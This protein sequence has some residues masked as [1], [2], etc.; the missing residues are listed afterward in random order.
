M[1][2]ERI[3]RS[4]AHTIGRIVEAVIGLVDRAGYC[5]A[6]AETIA[7]YAGCDRS[8]VFR[9]W[10]EI[11]FSG[12]LVSVRQAHGPNRV[13]LGSILI[14]RMLELLDT[15][16]WAMN[17]ASP[18]WLRY[19]QWLGQSVA[20]R[21]SRAALEP[22]ALKSR[23]NLLPNCLEDSDQIQRSE[24][25][26]EPGAFPPQSADDTTA[27]PT[28]KG[29]LRP[30]LC[31]GPCLPSL[32]RETEQ[33]SGG[34]NVSHTHDGT[35]E[36][37]RSPKTIVTPGRARVSAALQAV[38]DRWPAVAARL[39]ERCLRNLVAFRHD[40]RRIDQ[41]LAMA[42]AQPIGSFWRG[43]SAWVTMALKRN[44]QPNRHQ[45]RHIDANAQTRRLQRDSAR[46][47]G[48]PLC[49]DGSAPPAAASSG[50]P[51][52]ASERCPPPRPADGPPVVPSSASAAP[53]PVSPVVQLLRASP[54]LPAALRA[55]LQALARTV[56]PP[57]GSPPGEQP[58][59]AAVVAGSGEPL[60][61]LAALFAEAAAAGLAARRT[62]KKVHPARRRCAAA[63]G[64]LSL[65]EP[66]SLSSSPPLPGETDAPA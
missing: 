59:T 51:P 44:L 21:H 39:D 16:G 60:I 57:P 34:G 23:L 26:A 40:L 47:V 49:Q 35:A 43:V 50:E 66:P 18:F 4:R 17:P 24:D 5:W 56:V 3:S 12:L 31:S 38:L 2:H 62:R 10:P 52:P 20:Y 11:E 30:P 63:P 15:P 22:S 61:D 53:P 28:G 9:L 8:T 27:T 45:Q 48:D 29:A 64:Q 36:Q 41:V 58:P 65:W 13:Y 42:D 6:S 14:D 1:V 46:G 25:L 33:L 7:S 55:R 54:H 37:P 32:G 19:R